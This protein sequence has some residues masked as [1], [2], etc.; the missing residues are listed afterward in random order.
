[1]SEEE[2]RI[3]M[4]HQVRKGAVAALLALILLMPMG[5]V[6]A[7]AEAPAQYTFTSFDFP[8]AIVTQAYGINPGG[9]IVGTYQLPTDAASVVWPGTKQSHG[10]LLKNGAFSSFDFPGS[11]GAV[12]DC[13][14]ATS[15]TPGG[16]IAGYYGV[17]G[18]GWTNAEGF[19][20]SKQGEWSTYSAPLP[21]TDPFGGQLAMKP[22]PFRI[23]P[24]GRTVG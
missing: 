13:T 6:Y 20:Y 18:K 21:P 12:T 22:S 7:A 14:I 19:L 15:I 11:S 8:G 4:H 24:D 17:V 5:G 16:D 2:R 10:F 9:D 3:K 1:M 23:L